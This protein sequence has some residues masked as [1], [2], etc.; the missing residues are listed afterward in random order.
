MALFKW[1]TAYYPWTRLSAPV[2]DGSD[3]DG[4][5]TPPRRYEL[6]GMSI[7]SRYLQMYLLFRLR[8]GCLSILT[9]I[10]GSLCFLRFAPVSTVLSHMLSTLCA[11]DFI[12]TIPS[13]YLARLCELF[14][15][16]RYTFV[17]DPHSDSN[18]PTIHLSQ[19]RINGPKV[20]ERTKQLRA[21]RYFK[22]WLQ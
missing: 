11:N 9:T 21:V 17:G 6:L 20:V 1:R 5:K 2:M 4:A 15:L 8:R 18:C 19:P 14:E 3:I 10:V 13:L 7:R 12:S 22:V 16:L